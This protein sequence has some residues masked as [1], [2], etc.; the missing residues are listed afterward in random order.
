M[1]L[2]EILITANRTS[3]AVDQT[4][5][6]VTVLD[7]P[8]IER[9]QA[10]DLPSLLKTL[11]GIQISRNGGSGQ[12]NSIF[13]R[14]QESDH[15]LVLIDGV[16]VG[17]ATAG[18]T[19][20]QFLP[21]SQIERIEVIRGPRAS[22]YGSEAVGGVIQLFTR[23]TGEKNQT[24]SVGIGSEQTAQL[25]ANYANLTERTQ[26]QIGLE[27]TQTAGYN[28][29]ST[30]NQ[31]IG[32]CF[33]IEPDNDAHRQH[34]L[35][36]QVKHEFDPLTVSAQ[37][38]RSQG[39]TDYDSSFNNQVDFVQQVIGISAEIPFHDHQIS[40]LQLGESR[41]EA[42]NFGRAELPK[43]QY[44]TRLYTF[45]WQHDWTL[46]AAQLATF[47]YD[48]HRATIDSDSPYAM[49]RRDNHGVFAQYQVDFQP[50]HFQI[51][52]RFDDNEQF[53][54]YW[55]GHLG[56][57]YEWSPMIRGFASWGRAFKAPS[58]N[59]LYFPHFGNPHLE[60][61]Q[62]Q[63]WEVG[64][65]GHYAAFAWE[66]SGFYTETTQLIA[67][68]FDANT[69][70]FFPKNIAETTAKGIEFAATWALSPRWSLEGQIDVLRA[71]DQ[72]TGLDLPRRADYTGRFG[73]TGHFDRWQITTQGIA[74][75]ARH[76]DVLNQVHL[77]G[78]LTLDLLTEY[79]WSSE[80]TFKGRLSNL[81]DKDYEEARYFPAQGRAIFL[82]VH[83]RQ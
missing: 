12:N 48:F 54:D 65:R 16:K 43:N 77:P 14:G 44:D 31:G 9:S 51:S 20:W 15:V 71:E 34:A 60:P 38:L 33:T 62:A 76:D 49:T 3:R 74:Q 24:F 25:T 46:S 58:F 13:M 21:L 64:L 4:I 37:V 29:C 72:Q 78:Y 81:L 52:G 53:G 1:V 32:G 61:E 23:R 56:L 7:R 8:A 39:R 66:L 18:L 63:S 36:A 2:P 30:R 70:A 59:E 55:T 75:S 73:V 57:G 79:R 19:A 17:S 35:S 82:S 10:I 45:S 69:G 11:P 68:Y 6:A 40:R 41:D 28:A 27:H 42:E 22:L 50:L 26:Y 80:W 83:Y 67:T 5:A 47:G